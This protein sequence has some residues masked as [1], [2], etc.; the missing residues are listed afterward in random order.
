M[1][2]NQ[3][4]CEQQRDALRAF[5]KAIAVRA[6][7]E[8]AIT[9]EGQRRRQA[10]ETQ[11]TTQKQRVETDHLRTQGDALTRMEQTQ[12][13]VQKRHERDRDKLQQ[14][15]HS[16]HEAISKEYTDA[17]D[18]LEAE[19]REARWTTNTMYEA[20]KRVAK[21]AY[22][23]SQDRSKKLVRTQLEHWRIGKKS[24]EGWDFL[25]D[26]PKFDPKQLPSQFADPWQTLEE[27]TQHAETYQVA[28][29]TMKSPNFINSRIPYLIFFAVWLTLSLIASAV[30]YTV[31]KFDSSGTEGGRFLMLMVVVGGLLLVTAALVLAPGLLLH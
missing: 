29:T 18:S 4:W 12:L 1:F 27:C 24:I 30:Y 11:Y 3:P 31:G 26:V 22:L 28:L 17:K 2:M 20:D 8:H 15:F 13:D 14:E 25:D 6:E 10:T 16:I 5:R 9:T 7:R 19:F 21:E 23:A